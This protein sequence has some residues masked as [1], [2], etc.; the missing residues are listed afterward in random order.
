MAGFVLDLVV[1]EA[2]RSQA[3][4]S[5]ALEPQGVAGLRRRRAVIAPAIGLDDEAELRPEKVD[6]E[7]VDHDFRQR[8]RQ[9]GDGRER[10]EE[11]FELVVG[12]AEGVLVEDFAQRADAGLAGA[13][14]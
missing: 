6:L 5:V 14:V 7:F 4:R 3:R 1:G 12:E 13:V 10:A 2:E 9:P 11:P 8:H